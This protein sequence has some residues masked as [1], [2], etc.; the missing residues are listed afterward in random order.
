MLCCMS[1]DKYFMNAHCLAV[2]VFDVNND[3]GRAF[4]DFETNYI[5]V[6]VVVISAV[7]NALEAL[8]INTC[9]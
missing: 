3:L 1:L 7:V 6:N 8:K 5:A 9:E 2:D 4:D